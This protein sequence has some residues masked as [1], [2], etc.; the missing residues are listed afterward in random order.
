MREK[1]TQQGLLLTPG[2]IDDFVKF[3]RDDIALTGKI[4]ADGK[5]RAE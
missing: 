3:Q 1:L 4:I 5:I 2:S